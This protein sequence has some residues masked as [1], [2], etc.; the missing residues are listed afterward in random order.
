MAD[1][2]K[3]LGARLR[4]V[5]HREGVSTRPSASTPTRRSAVGPLRNLGD[6]EIITADYI[7]GSTSSASCTA[8]AGSH[9]PKPRLAT[10]PST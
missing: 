4:D 1:Y 3:V 5:R 8:S 2:V 6:V 10:M 7:A 9:Q